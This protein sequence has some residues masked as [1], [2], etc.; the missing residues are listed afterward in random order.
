MAHDRYLL[1]DNVKFNT[2]AFTLLQKGRFSEIK[3]TENEIPFDEYWNDSDS[4]DLV[5]DWGKIKPLTIFDSKCS[6]CGIAIQLPFKPDG[7][8]PVYCKD[9][10]QKHRK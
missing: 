1:G 5:K 3:K 4:Y 10:L 7:K 8:R 6:D 2:V 9:C